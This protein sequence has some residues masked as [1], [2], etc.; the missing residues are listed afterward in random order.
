V[1][2]AI[3]LVRYAQ[4]RRNLPPSPNS[5]TADMPADLSTSDR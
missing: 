5:A 2:G 1:F 3:A 4:G